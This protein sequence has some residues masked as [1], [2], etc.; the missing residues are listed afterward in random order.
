M[1]KKRFS[2][3]DL[4]KAKKVN[5]VQYFG[6]KTK[7]GYSFFEST[8]NP[9][10][11]LAYSK[12]TKK[13]LNAIDAVITIEGKRFVCAVQSLL[14]FTPAPQQQNNQESDIL[15]IYLENL[16]NAQIQKQQEIE[17]KA[18]RIMATPGWQ[19]EVAQRFDTAKTEIEKQALEKKEMQEILG[20][21]DND[22]STEWLRLG[23]NHEDIKK[24]EVLE[25]L[26]CDNI[27]ELRLLAKSNY[28]FAAALTRDLSS[29]RQQWDRSTFMLLGKKSRK[30]LDVMISDDIDIEIES[31][32][33]LINEDYWLAQKQNLAPSPGNKTK[34]QKNTVIKM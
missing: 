11:W 26:G 2:S 23:G 15:D 12:E 10:H 7:N 6:A 28:A 20:Y 32:M 24:A 1:E 30:I 18:E 5:L 17:K 22:I 19:K 34:Q 4:N 27:G 29:D 13:T 9:G 14:N 31:I 33:T 8:K 21:N 3:E 16:E 25:M